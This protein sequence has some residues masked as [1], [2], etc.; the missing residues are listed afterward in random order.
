MRKTLILMLLLI[1]F[2]PVNDLMAQDCERL[3]EEMAAALDKMQEMAK[4]IEGKVLSEAAAQ[5]FGQRMKAAS[6]RAED[7]R[8]R[9]MACTGMLPL[10]KLNH[11][12]RQLKMRPVQR[13]QQGSLKN[14]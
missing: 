14:S 9:W 6:D 12:S 2:L 3:G 8:K 4:E 11:N 7:A 5:A 13:K 1:G 10:M